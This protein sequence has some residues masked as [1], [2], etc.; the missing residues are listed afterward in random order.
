MIMQS[1]IEESNFGSSPVSS[2]RAQ[3]AYLGA[4]VGDALGWPHE[5]RAHGSV[6]QSS[7]EGLVYESWTKRSGGRFQPHDEKIAVGEYSDD[8]QLILAV[9]RA[10][11][12]GG[13]NWW[14]SFSREELPFWTVYERGGG[15]ATRRAANTWL[16][17]RKPWKSGNKEEMSKYFSSG[18][19]GAAMRI[20]AHCLGRSGNDQFEELA[21][22]IMTDG[23]CT[24]GHPRALIG[25]LAYGYGLWMAFRHSGT[26]SYGQL[27]TQVL[28]GA[29]AWTA[30]PKIESRW[31]DWLLTA[32]SILDYIGLW[33][34]VANEQKTLLSI[35][36]R[37]I[38]EGAAVNDD[39]MLEELGCFNPKVN[40]AGTVAAAAALF[41]ASRHAV[42]P[43]EGV[44]KA[45]L[46]NGADT[47][48]IASM[49]GG[50]LGA[51]VGGEW[52]SSYLHDLQ[53]ANAIRKMAD[54][55]LHGNRT[56]KQSGLV[57]GITRRSV[58][59]LMDQL[60]NVSRDTP[61]VLP[62]GLDS[63]AHPWS[64]WVA[65]SKSIEIRGWRIRSAEGQTFFIKELLRR[66]RT[67]TYEETI[68]VAK[69]VAP[70]DYHI[71]GVGFRLTVSDLSRSTVFYRDVIGLPVTRETQT[72]VSFGAVL[73]ITLSRSGFVQE[74]ALVMYISVSNV[75][76]C[77]ERL[78]RN[79]FIVKAKD[80][81]KDGTGRISC[82][83]PDGYPLVIY[84]DNTTDSQSFG[85]TR[86]AS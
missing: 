1:R 4:A 50:I 19:N 62:I 45:A 38:E 12:S 20:L 64:G 8:T 44:R 39:E 27:L 73:S 37:G 6:L 9:S 49:T 79:G 58:S 82:S 36:N 77:A 59:R 63:V 54:N 81:E 32:E 13:E 72:A 71:G 84:Q 17:G 69:A 11:I 26:L 18:G 68:Q 30:L 86:S 47:D 7:A 56:P 74:N 22:D 28:A 16:N 60:R 78:K 61:I 70:I 31:R 24:H 66:S 2:Q 33:R 29:E 46:A 83:D 35:A 10:I 41:L 34:D 43:I 57:P 23:V 42:D 76:H 75:N 48:T 85:S 53:D 14:H 21:S 40:G 25:A 67:V 55:I 51:A 80:S 5:V 52:L 65:R 3:A 15:G